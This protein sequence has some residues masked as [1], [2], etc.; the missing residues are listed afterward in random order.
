MPFVLLI[1]LQAGDIANENENQS[2]FSTGLL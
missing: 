1:G 2:Y